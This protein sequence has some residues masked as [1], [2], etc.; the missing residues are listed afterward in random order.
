MATGA[1]NCRERGSGHA[2]SRRVPA[3]GG[4]ECRDRT[5]VRRLGRLRSLLQPPLAS[6]RRGTEQAD[7]PGLRKRPAVVLSCGRGRI[8]VQAP[9]HLVQALRLSQHAVVHG[10]L[11]LMPMHVS[12]YGDRQHAPGSQAR[13]RA[14]SQGCCVESVGA[15]MM[16][17]REITPTK[18]RPRSRAGKLRAFKLTISCRTRVSGAVGSTCSFPTDH[19]P[20]PVGT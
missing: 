11:H 8:D 4:E 10:P 14:G 13:L 20:S 2:R 15:R 9:H 19:P 6:C 1:L 16:S 5:E 17:S 3:A 7:G 18:R 12:P